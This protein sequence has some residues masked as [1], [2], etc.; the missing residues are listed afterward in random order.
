[1]IRRDIGE[2]YTENIVEP[3]PKL[4]LGRHEFFRHLPY[5]SPEYIPLVDKARMLS[6]ARADKAQAES[7]AA[8]AMERQSGSV[9]SETA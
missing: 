4:M 2:G 7:K 5:L 3:F 9:V 1:M 6:E 8:I